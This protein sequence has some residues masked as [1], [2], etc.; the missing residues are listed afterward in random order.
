MEIEEV[1]TS[2]QAIAHPDRHH[3]HHHHHHH[4]SHVFF[5][6]WDHDVHRN[7]EN[8]HFHLLREKWENIRNAIPRT[9]AEMDNQIAW[10]S[11]VE[12]DRKEE[13][14]KIKKKRDDLQKKVNDAIKEDK[15]ELKK[16][17]DHNEERQLEQE[18]IEH[19]RDLAVE[20]LVETKL[21]ED[22]IQKVDDIARV[23]GHLSRAV[24]PRGSQRA[25]NVFAQASGVGLGGRGGR[26]GTGGT[27][28]TA[29]QETII[30]DDDHHRHHHE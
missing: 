8:P 13:E 18:R 6:G 16:L 23:I 9:F 12:K 30:Y 29:D 14:E 24:T 5:P 26:G 19:K 10:R 22:P 7:V 20:R 3:H 21:E 25:V 11:K 15:E 28:G 4:L 17:E 2:L 1:N 27:G